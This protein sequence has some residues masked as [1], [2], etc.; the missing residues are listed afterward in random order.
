MLT[1]LSAPRHPLVEH[2]LRQAR[3]WCAGQVIDERPALAHAVRVA[4]VLG[5]YVTDAAPELIAAA[6]L[7]DAPEFAPSHVDLDLIL[8][9]RYG[10]E[11]ARIVRAVEVAHHALESAAP[12]IAVEDLPVLLVCT[13]D[14]IVALESLLL[15]AGT[16]G[17]VEGFFAARPGLLRL[18]PHFRAFCAAAL[19]RVPP[20]MS[21]RLDQVLQEMAEATTTTVRARTA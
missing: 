3:Q 11:V 13:A 7:H 9:R 12:I 21:V 19:G 10:A 1:V 17:D 4:L 8:G 18:L 14:K 5:R 15:R 20:G 6:L 16:S 2:A